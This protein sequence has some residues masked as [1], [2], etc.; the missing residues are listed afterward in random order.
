MSSWSVASGIKA[1]APH[2]VAGH[3]FAWQTPIHAEN[4]ASRAG[5]FSNTA[6]T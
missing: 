6:L 3:N 4:D 1:A 2:H 5:K